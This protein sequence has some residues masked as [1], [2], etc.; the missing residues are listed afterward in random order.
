MT[1]ARWIP[2]LALAVAMGCT[3][4]ATGSDPADA[5]PP[6]MMRAIRDFAHDATPAPSA[7]VKGQIVDEAGKPIPLAF[8]SICNPYGCHSTDAD[9]DGN[10]VING[11]QLGDCG[12][13]THENLD[14]SPRLGVTVRLLH[15]PDPVM[16]DGGKLYVPNM[17]VGAAI[18]LKSTTPQ[19][20]ELGDGVTITVVGKDLDPPLGFS[21]ENMVAR[22]IKPEHW[23]TFDLGGEQILGVYSTLPYATKSASPVGFAAT[24]AGTPGD[25]VHIRSIDEF[26]GKFF[27]AVS[28]HVSVD[29]KSVSTDPGVGLAVLSWVIVSR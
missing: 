14:L 4:G 2:M 3:N 17:G 23:P 12:L 7:S 1:A 27:P 6:D 24:L 22:A 13:R 21:A 19:A 8:A 15:L 10:F 29:G 26:N 25:A 18:D 20:Y 9:A 16:V 11:I 28:G 5:A